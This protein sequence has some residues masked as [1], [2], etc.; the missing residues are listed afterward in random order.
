MTPKSPIEEQ[1]RF[2][3]LAQYLASKAPPGK[4]PGRQHIDPLDMADLLPFLMLVDVIRQPGGEPRYRIRL[5]GTEVV[6]IQ[7][8]DGTGKFVE[9]VLTGPEG[10]AIIRAYGEILSTKQPQ[11]RRGVVATSGREHVFYERV[12]FP[13]SA[14]GE[15]V[16]MLIFVFDNVARRSEAN[17]DCFEPGNGM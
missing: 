1:P 15:N 7:G 4:L 8:S 14:D 12:A 17:G 11:Y 16:D 13:L 6:A 10:A 2:R 3:R 9:E 5:V